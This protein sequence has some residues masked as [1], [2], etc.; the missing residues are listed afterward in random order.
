[1]QIPIG[2]PSEENVAVCHSMSVSAVPLSVDEM[3]VLVHAYA[4]GQP[5]G[6]DPPRPTSS[7]VDFQSIIG[8][9]SGIHVKMQSVFH[10]ASRRSADAA[11]M[12]DRT[13]NLLRDVEGK[14]MQRES[15][16]M[17]EI[18]ARNAQQ[19]E[20]MQAHQESLRTQVTV[21]QTQVA[22]QQEEMKKTMQVQVTREREE[23]QS[24]MQVLRNS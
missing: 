21:T 10:D 12:H 18:E 13:C 24:L 17:N 19:Q 7:S 11:E 4:P 22:R 9:L 1:M 5:S 23:M 16:F 3:P 15:H 6:V 14:M 20:V 8:M 2:S